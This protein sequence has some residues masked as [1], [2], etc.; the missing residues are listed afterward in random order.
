LLFLKE[1]VINALF[2][3][4]LFIYSKHA[5]YSIYDQLNIK[6]IMDRYYHVDRYR[7]ISQAYI[8]RTGEIKHQLPIVQL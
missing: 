3:S 1:N 4:S 7:V 6:Y 5:W 8:I 2:K